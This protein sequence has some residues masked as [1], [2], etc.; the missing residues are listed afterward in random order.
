[1]VIAVALS[2]VDGYFGA[3][4]R[5]LST[6]QA[7][8]GK[9]EGRSMAKAGPKAPSAKRAGGS[10]RTPR[11]QPAPK[12][13]LDV[14]LTVSLKFGE[15]PNDTMTVMQD[16]RIPMVD[17]IFRNRDRV[18]RGLAQIL[19]RAGL[20]QPKIAAQLLPLVHRQ[21]RAAPKFRNGI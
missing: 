12:A 17:S 18:F 11:R 2:S 6:W 14:R 4:S 7:A 9:R 5:S 20:T 1:M 19:L 8:T 10:A 21:L 3:A 16:R 13:P 15:A